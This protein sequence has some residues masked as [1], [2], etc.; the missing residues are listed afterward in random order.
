MLTV[1]RLEIPVKDHG[2]PRVTSRLRV[3]NQPHD[4]T[5]CCGRVFTIVAAVQRADDLAEDAP[6]KLLLA[7]L[8]L[9]LQ[10]PDDA[11]QVA[12]AAVFH[13]QVKVLRGLDVVTLEVGDDVRVAELFQ[14][15]EFG[16][17]LLALLLRHLEIADLFPAENLGDG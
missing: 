3:A 12:V 6:H 5:A 2:F 15:R 14:D 13:V 16:L 11:P 17:E 7:H 1:L 4:V 10:V 9:V 8:V